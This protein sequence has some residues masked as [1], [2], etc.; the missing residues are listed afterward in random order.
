VRILLLTTIGRKTGQK[1]SVPLAA[2][3]YGNDFIVVAS[4]GG[5]PKNPSWF[6]NLKHNPSVTVQVGNSIQKADAWIVEATD[7]RYEG[8]WALALT[9]YNGFATYRRKTLR[10]IPL[11]II[12]PHHP[13]N[14][15]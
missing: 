14:Y 10:D 1:R 9:T 6:V 11:V 8:F 3:S 2:I 15:P 5:H 12:R 7:K 13:N 4:F